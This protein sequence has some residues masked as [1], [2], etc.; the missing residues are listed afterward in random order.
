MGV[1]GAG[2]VK[3]RVVDKG[4]RGGGKVK[5][6]VSEIRGGGNGSWV[7]EGKGSG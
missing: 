4:I 5:S 3:K 1:K 2:W 6:G 7:D